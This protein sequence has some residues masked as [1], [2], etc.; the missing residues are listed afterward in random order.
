PEVKDIFDFKY[1]DFTLADYDA[2]PHI[3]AEVAV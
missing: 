1:E 3:K 2:Q